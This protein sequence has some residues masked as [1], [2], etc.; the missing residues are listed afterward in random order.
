MGWYS[1]TDKGGWGLLAWLVGTGTPQQI[2]MV[3]LLQEPW[4]Y[5]LNFY[6]CSEAG[7]RAIPEHGILSRVT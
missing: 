5:A 6:L 1:T 2:D 4:Y 7:E 3:A